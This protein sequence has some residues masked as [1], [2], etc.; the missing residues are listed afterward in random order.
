MIAWT[1]AHWNDLLAIFGG[2]VAVASLIVKLTPSP[3][4]DAWLAW[5]IRVLDT[6]SVVNPNDDKPR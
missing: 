2:V 5:A 3:K 6:F 1:Q 4:D